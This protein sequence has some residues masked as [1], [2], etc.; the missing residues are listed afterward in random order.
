MTDLGLWSFS[1][2]V[3]ILQQLLTDVATAVN[4]CVRGEKIFFSL[5][6]SKL[7]AASVLTE[8]AFFFLVSNIFWVFFSQQNKLI[9]RR[10]LPPLRKD[11][12]WNVVYLNQRFG[13]KKTTTL[14]SLIINESLVSIHLPPLVCSPHEGVG[15][16]ITTT[17]RISCSLFFPYSI[18][19]ASNHSKDALHPCRSTRWNCGGLGWFPLL[20]K[21]PFS[22]TAVRWQPH[23]FYFYRT[24]CTLNPCFVHL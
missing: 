18:H 3:I 1:S 17:D 11:L 14:F 2:Q 5:L 23:L 13:L 19:E 22:A 9:C 24:N 12:N 10:D 8:L 16:L 20:W 4:S 15:A 21:K 6:F 7:T